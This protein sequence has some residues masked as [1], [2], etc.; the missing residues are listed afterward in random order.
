M[1]FLSYNIFPNLSTF[2]LITVTNKL[3]VNRFFNDLSLEKSTFLDNFLP[4]QNLKVA[5]YRNGEPSPVPFQMDFFG[6]THRIYGSF[7]IVNKKDQG[8]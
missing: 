5:I 8:C 1:L 7:E 6:I 3:K 2:R 4:L